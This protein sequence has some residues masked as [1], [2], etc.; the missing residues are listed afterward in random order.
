[1]G[2]ETVTEENCV[3]RVITMRENAILS[4]NMKKDTISKTV[5]VMS[6]E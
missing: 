4:E 1:M 5:S 6:T 2:E 3:D